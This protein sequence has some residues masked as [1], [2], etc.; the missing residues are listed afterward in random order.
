MAQDLKLISLFKSPKADSISSGKK[1]GQILRVQKTVQK[2]AHSEPVWSRVDAQQGIQVRD[3]VLTM[4]NS[5]ALLQIQGGIEILIS[6]NNLITFEFN[7]SSIDSSQIKLRLGD[8]QTW[9]TPRPNS[10]LVIHKKAKSGQQDK[11]DVAEIEVLQG[12]V[13]AEV[14]AEIRPGE[15][16]QKW[17]LGPGEKFE[18]SSNHL[19]RSPSSASSI[20]Q[21]IPESIPKKKP[22]RI[23]A[24][25]SDDF[26]QAPT[27]KKPKINQRKTPGTWFQLLVSK[28]WAQDLKSSRS[29]I[30]LSWEKVPKADSYWVEI[31]DDKEFKINLKITEVP[32]NEINWPVDADSVFY[33]RVAAKKNAI[34][35]AKS[36]PDRVSVPDLLVSGQAS[37][38]RLQIRQN[39]IQPPV[40]D[41][42]YFVNFGMVGLNTFY[43]DSSNSLFKLFGPEAQLGLGLQNYR[44]KN[45]PHAS[46]WSSEFNYQYGQ[47][48]S[49]EG[50][51]ATQSLKL[52]DHRLTFLQLNHLSPKTALGIPV[53]YQTMPWRANLEEV[54]LYF[55][56]LSGLSYRH[57]FSRETK[58]EFF[59]LTDLKFHQMRWIFHKSLSKLFSQ[60]WS[61]T[62]Q[63]SYLESPS[64]KGAEIQLG[65]R[66]SF[67]W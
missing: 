39:V 27:L 34:I 51:L 64:F 31:A 45:S 19:Q 65:L 33:W 53:V 9:L 58:L 42:T 38:S 49:T 61:M 3:S 48:K 25:Q 21:E 35:G 10:K 20:S 28:A 46:T 6:E 14:Q 12:K 22:K 11:L 55:R 18:L 66:S 37:D 5:S 63:I 57:S 62:S 52:N 30:L 4:E 24:Q 26:L 13:Q 41:K 67:F 59:I 50:F 1:I 40:M 17:L 60:N 32:S 43:R 23:P 15:K 8:S 29:S 36:L 2:R 7:E 16:N 47:W 54:G 56:T 44:L